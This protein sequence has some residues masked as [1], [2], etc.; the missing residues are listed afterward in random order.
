MSKLTT[1]INNDHVH[2]GCCQLIS[3]S[4]KDD[5]SDIEKSDEEGNN[6]IHQCQW[7]FLSNDKTPR[8]E[9]CCGEITYREPNKPWHLLGALNPNWSPYFKVAV[10]QKVD[11]MNNFMYFDFCKKDKPCDCSI[12]LCVW[13]SETL[14]IN[15]QYLM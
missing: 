14:E 9:C 4:K 8:W 15:S 2:S 11:D 12:C 13:T 3:Q 7:L 5:D 1:D 10:E 6:A